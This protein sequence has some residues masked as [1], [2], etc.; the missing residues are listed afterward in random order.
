MSTPASARSD[1]ARL[2]DLAVRL[3]NAVLDSASVDTIGVAHWW[4]RARSALEVGAASATDWP[5]M[6][7]AI[8]RRLQVDGALSP[9]SAETV[10]QLGAE[11]TATPGLLERLADHCDRNAVYVVALARMARKTQ[12]ADRQAARGDTST[13]T[14]AATPAPA[15]LPEEPMF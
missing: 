10:T 3:I 15:P 8:C 12:R 13:P 9:Q 4:D 11:L 5:S 7:S 2:D 1:A 14:P 6:V